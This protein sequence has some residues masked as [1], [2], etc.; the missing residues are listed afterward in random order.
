LLEVE[1]EDTVMVKFDEV[2]KGYKKEQV[3]E[4]INTVSA[5]YETLH[6]ELKSAREELEVLKEEEAKLQKEIKSLNSEE[7]SSYQEVIASAILSAEASAKKI[8]E[9]AKKESAHVNEIAKKELAVINQTKQGA[10]DEV[11]KLTDNLLV[12][13]RDEQRSAEIYAKYTMASQEIE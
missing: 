11:Q 7:H 10:I 13:L 2:K 5:E 1:R 4:Y 3:D 9:D 6:E 8:V 12:L